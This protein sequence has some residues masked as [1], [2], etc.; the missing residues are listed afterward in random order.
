MGLSSGSQEAQ[1]ETPTKSAPTKEGLDYAKEIFELTSKS[2]LS[3]DN[4]MFAAQAGKLIDVLNSDAPNSVK[5]KM[6]IQLQMQANDVVN[7]YALWKEA[8]KKVSEED[9]GSDLA[10][11]SRGGIYVID[12]ETRDITSKSLSDIKENS[13]KYHM[14]TWNELLN[15]RYYN[16]K[17]AFDV[18][19]IQNASSA[20]GMKEIMNQ[21]TEIIHKIGKEE[22][23]GYT[24]KIGN[25][26]Q[27]GLEYLFAP[28]QTENGTMLASYDG[29][30][31]FKKTDSNAAK[32]IDAAINY[33][34]THLTDGAKNVVRA[35]AY[36]MGFKNPNQLIELAIVE[37]ISSARELDYV[38]PEDDNDSKKGSGSGSGSK[39]DLTD[40]IGYGQMLSQ[41]YGRGKVSSFRLKG[42]N[43]QIEIK[44]VNNDLRDKDN[45][46][47]TGLITLEKAFDDLRSHGVV[48]D[49]NNITFGQTKIDMN[50][51]RDI[52]VDAS[53]GVDTVDIPVD[54]NG[55]LNFDLINNL[56]LAEQE[57]EK[58]NIISPQ[59]KREVYWKYMIQTDSNG[60]PITMRY[61]ALE[62]KMSSKDVP[63][64]ELDPSI[65]TMDTSSKK[66]FRQDVEFY[67]QKRDKE[68]KI[69]P[70]SGIF[71]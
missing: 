69:D 26:V 56:Y 45:N 13:D 51:S 35:N 6:L 16:T 15:S 66:K 33:I 59:D 3:S 2:G 68:D 39:E 17:M 29:L 14:L 20:I 70:A 49:R 25:T 22:N 8:A 53:K 41:G 61:Y 67:N 5:Q 31:N 36:K 1:S 46:I 42:S 4:T 19:P 27:K 55:N 57:I 48:Q 58:N 65:D 43:K 52:V 54:M 11:D 38:K 60:N 9:L 50:L 32:S 44:S 64:Y 18:D 37:N 62:A 63:E 12:T 21:V 40:K 24:A 23:K 47:E 30:Y 10:M 7:N 34:Y 71:N 28:V